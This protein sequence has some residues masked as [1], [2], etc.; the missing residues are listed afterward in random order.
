MSAFEPLLALAR[1]LTAALSAEDR[2]QRL[3][4]LAGRIIPADASTLLRCDDGVLVPLATDGLVPQARALRFPL[5]EHP[6][7]AAICAAPG[8]LH[9]PADSALPDPFD[10]LVE[11]GAELADVHSCLGCPLRVE[12]ALVGV[13]TADALRPDAFD[14][15]D[16]K[17]LAL[18]SALAGAALRTGALI[19]ALEREAAR[20]G[21]VARDLARDALGRGEELLGASPAMGKLRQAIELVAGTDLTVL[22]LGETGVGK[23][24]VARA[25]HRGS[26]R[27]GAPLLY[28]NC[29]ALPESVAESE[30]FGHVRGAFTGA[31]S[32]RPGKFELADG[33]TLLL[34]EIGE[35]PLAMQAKLLRVLQE[36]EIQRVGS[37][38]VTHVDVRIIAATNR[39]LPAEVARGRFRADLYHR[40]HVYSLTVPPLR[41]RR[42]DVAALAGHFC[43]VLRR[44]LGLGPVR[45]TAAAIAGLTRHPW[46]GNVRE[47]E[48]LLAR[49]VLTASLGVPTGETVVVDSPALGLP[50]APTPAAVA[51][52]P[53]TPQPLREAVDAFRR[54]TI[55]AALARAGG[56]W[57]AAAAQLGLDRSNLHRLGKRLGLR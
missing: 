16:D 55:S 50:G 54:R 43:E 28:L 7:L 15:L 44:R 48:N 19:E 32:D 53:A 3:L 35:L 2:Y 52:E 1:D 31:R 39:D 10:G 36:G 27:S 21:Q 51:P 30:L 17:V 34:D 40:L 38:R 46:P 47:L 6:R 24:L 18:L 37:G 33:G 26:A 22:I 13:L 4:A 49:V 41:A 12:G 56:N 45:L 14:A 11:G 29:A 25:V 5:A 8:P 20:S 9:F 42:E 23:E 57:S